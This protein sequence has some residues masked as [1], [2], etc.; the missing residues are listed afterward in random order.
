[1]HHSQR[2]IS[3]NVHESNS[4]GFINGINNS[5]TPQITTIQAEHSSS[6]IINCNDPSCSYNNCSSMMSDNNT[7]HAQTRI[8]SSNNC[9][10]STNSILCNNAI[11][12]TDHSNHQQ[13]MPDN[14]PSPSQSQYNDQ[15]LSQSNLFPLFHS[16]SI[17]IN[18][19][20][21]NITIMPVVNSSDIQNQHQQ[22]TNNSRQQ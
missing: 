6:N 16:L 21:T 11:N 22:D 4:T 20:Q 5:N 12:S 13:F 2:N 3:N 1:M 7:L 18:S 15:N 8:P 14:A 9:Q 19:P 17:I 10:Q